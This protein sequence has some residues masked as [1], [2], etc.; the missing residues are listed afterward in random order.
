[1]TRLT[2]NKATREWEDLPNPSETYLCKHGWSWDVL[3]R[4]D[5]CDCGGKELR[6]GWYACDCITHQLS[7]K[8]CRMPYTLKELEVGLALAKLRGKNA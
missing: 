5:G 6:P 1:M 7:D 3:S 8:P 4:P 2:F